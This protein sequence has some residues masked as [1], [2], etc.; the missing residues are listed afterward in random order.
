MAE[1]LISYAFLENAVL[2]ETHFNTTI[3]TVA[4]YF[5][6]IQLN[7][8][9]LLCVFFLVGGELK[10]NFFVNRGDIKICV[11]CGTS[12]S[13]SYCRVVLMNVRPLVNTRS[14]FFSNK[15]RTILSRGMFNR[16]S[17]ILVSV[18]C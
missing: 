7:R 9:C 18:L 4:L 17:K 3:T 1:I 14:F 5:K 15:V 11:Y 2:D 8:G 10:I 16:L 6:T 12:G 13:S